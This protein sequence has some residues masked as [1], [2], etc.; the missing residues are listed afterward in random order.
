MF[1]NFGLIYINLLSRKT[2]GKGEPSAQG[3]QSEAGEN[4]QDG[5]NGV[6]EQEGND[7]LNSLMNITVE[8]AGA[9]C[10]AS[11][12]KIDWSLDGNNGTLDYDE[13][14]TDDKVK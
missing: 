6:N 10:Y 1:F 5:T 3:L 2:T 7:G 13:P 9:N 11:G 8:P 4:G 14:N 12:V